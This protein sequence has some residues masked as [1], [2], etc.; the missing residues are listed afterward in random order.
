MKNKILLLFINILLFA[1]SIN[2]QK[3]IPDFTVTDIYKNRHTL[4]S[5][6]LDKGKYVFID[7]FSTTCPSC[8][9][10]APIVDTVFRDFGCN[11]GD[12]VFLA[13]ENGHDNQA[14]W[15]F[16]NNYVMTFPV[17]SGEEG[18]GNQVYTDFS[19]PWTPYK[20]LISPDG[21]IVSDN[22][23][24]FDETAQKLRDTLL[25]FGLTM[26]ECQGNDFMFYSLISDN[27]SVVGEIDDVN[28]SINVSFPNKTNISS[29][30]AFF[31][32][33]VN[34]TIT[35]NGVNQ[36]SSETIN[37]FS[38]PVNYVIT[39]EKGV[40]ETW[41][42]NVS[43]S[44]ITDFYNKKINIYPNPS[45]GIFVLENNNLKSKKV[46]ANLINLTGKIIKTIYLSKGDN[47]I[48]LSE[49]KKGIYFLNFKI[50]NV[51]INK[52]LILY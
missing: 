2:A 50:N 24:Q 26:Q 6:Y 13:I 35:V 39:S 19:I 9:L 10:L 5:N 27:D 43:T 38:S 32:N 42:V 4:K 23:Y 11:Y 3:G 47:I 44:S 12:L 16:T 21:V 48:D 34:S 29:L 52:E 31:R 20:L 1:S 28:K 33:A 40:S 8:N 15:D 49:L 36:I 37:D 30:K 7:F 46:K 45:N 51:P 25:T 41:T 14:N 22:P 17:A 18:N